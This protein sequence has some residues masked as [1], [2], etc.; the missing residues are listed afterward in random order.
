MGQALIL[1][2][3]STILWMNGKLKIELKHVVSTPLAVTQE[4][5]IVNK[6][7]IPANFKYRKYIIEPYN[8]VQ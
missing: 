4:S 5:K 2:L 7:L 3:V 8:Q 6:F 1:L